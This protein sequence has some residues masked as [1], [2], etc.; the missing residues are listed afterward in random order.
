[1]TVRRM[2]YPGASVEYLS[3]TDDS[4]A[5]TCPECKAVLASGGWSEPDG[6]EMCPDCDRY[7]HGGHLP[8]CLFVKMY[9]MRAQSRPGSNSSGA[10]LGAP[11]LVRHTHHD[12]CA[13]GQM[14]PRR[15]AK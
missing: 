14:L 15:L 12:R 4:A 10:W 7:P 2:R 9:G 1:M 11:L 5:V 13:C 6:R 8:R 3:L